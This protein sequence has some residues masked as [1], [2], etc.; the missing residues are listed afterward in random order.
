MGHSARVTSA[1][2]IGA[3]QFDSWE[4]RCTK[5]LQRDFNTSWF[6]ESNLIE[7][8]TLK[9]GNGER[10]RNVRSR[11]WLRS[12]STNKKMDP[13][14]SPTISPSTLVLA[15]HA[16]SNA[17]NDF[18]L[19]Q[20]NHFPIFA[21]STV[22]YICCVPKTVSPVRH[23]RSFWKVLRCY[24]PSVLSWSV[25]LVYTG[26]PRAHWGSWAFLQQSMGFRTVTEPIQYIWWIP[27]HT[28]IFGLSPVC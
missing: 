15:P 5:L 7:K 18:I 27:I 19:M 28:T 4:S 14:L 20:S 12:G 21:T 17:F 6:L 10:R 3:P 24:M 16:Y 26:L 13:P 2:I 9:P 23:Y 1:R 25:F 11:F 8:R 22:L